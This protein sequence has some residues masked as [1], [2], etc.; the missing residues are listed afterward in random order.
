LRTD[1]HPESLI[2]SIASGTG[3]AMKSHGHP[4]PGKREKNVSNY[5]FDH[6]SWTGTGSEMGFNLKTDL[7]L[8]SVLITI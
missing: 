6:E 1:T 5:S 7:F 8:A 2:N 4:F 3:M